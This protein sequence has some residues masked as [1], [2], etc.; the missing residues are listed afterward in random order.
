MVTKE[1]SLTQDLSQLVRHMKLWFIQT[2]N[3]DNYEAL[4]SCN[5]EWPPKSKHWLDIC[6]VNLK[7]KSGPKLAVDKRTPSVLT[8]CASKV[9]N[10]MNIPLPFTDMIV[11]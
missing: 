8:S 6:S 9:Y 3:Q 5:W 4:L 1:C 11:Q 10:Y 2:K 7:Q